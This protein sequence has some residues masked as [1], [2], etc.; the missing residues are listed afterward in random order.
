MLEYEWVWSMSVMD[1]RRW[2]ECDIKI[3]VFG[4]LTDL[5]DWPSMS[6]DWSCKN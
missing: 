2:S 3:R 4:K 6:V 5:I 1:V